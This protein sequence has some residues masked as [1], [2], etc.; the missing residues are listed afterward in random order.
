[1]IV[2]RSGSG[3]TS[4]VNA[5]QKRYGYVPLSS[6]TTRPRRSPD[7]VGHEFIS[8]E[9]FA[10]LEGVLGY[11]KFNGFEYCATQEQAGRSDLYTIDPPGIEYM[12][13]RY[14]SERPIKVIGIQVPVGELT[15]RMLKRGDTAD[16]VRSRLANDDVMFAG[17]D[18]V[19]DVIVRNDS[20][21]DT[22][23]LI[24]DLILRYEGV[25][26]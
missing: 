21:E 14:Q 10:M 16:M 25:S 13:E 3:K 23:E 12:L 19:C 7:E 17:M 20:F 1:M 4:I 5:L 9:A 2:G 22:V 24:H 15:L 8:S 6:Y 11:T 26:K 18:D